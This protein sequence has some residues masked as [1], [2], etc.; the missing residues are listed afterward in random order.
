MSRIFRAFVLWLIAVAIPA[1]GIA[2]IV[3][4]LG[5]AEPFATVAGAGLDGVG[6]VVMH[7]HRA[8]PDAGVM[9][10]AGEPGHCQTMAAHGSGKSST[11]DA[12]SAG[13]SGHGMLKCCSAG[14]SMAACP[15][16]GLA[17]HS[18]TPSLAPVQSE[19]S[20]YP[21]VILDGLDRPPRPLPA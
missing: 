11:P 4:P 18:R 2:A 7:G 9:A 15:A 16:P 8:A 10:H 20:F 13:H 19:A 12:D 5:V 1:Q 6:A 17:T 14:C 3:M 21:G